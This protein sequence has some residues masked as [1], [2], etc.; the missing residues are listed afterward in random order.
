MK[1]FQAGFA[2][3]IHEVIAVELRNRTAIFQ[4]QLGITAGQD[5]R[6]IEFIASMICR[7]SIILCAPVAKIPGAQTAA[8][9]DQENRPAR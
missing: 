6:T 3:E 7:C 8:R 5:D 4:L 2:D 1:F 9:A